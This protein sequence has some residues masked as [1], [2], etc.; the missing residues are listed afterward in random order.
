MRGAGGV[1]AERARGVPARA[2]AARARL[3]RAAHR[4]PAPRAHRAAALHLARPPRL[5]VT[6]PHHRL[7][8]R[9]ADTRAL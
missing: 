4:A 7:L 2:P 9:A 8:E 1:R 3:P 5:I 6:R